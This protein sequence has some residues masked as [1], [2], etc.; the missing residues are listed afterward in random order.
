MKVLRFLGNIIWL[1]CGGLLCALAYCI[2]GL[3]CCITVVGI[4]FG[5][6]LFKFARLWLTPFGK[7]VELNFGEHP[8]ANVIWLVLVGW[9]MFC[10]NL[11]SCLICCITIIGIP[12][13]LQAFKF[14][15]LSIAPF[16]AKIRKA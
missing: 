16:G 7:K 9:E 1:I 8:V 13:G 2:V 5:V 6:Q 12:V 3:F 4:P 14:S 10:A 11:V 15:V